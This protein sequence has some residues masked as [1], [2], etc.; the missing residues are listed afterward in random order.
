MFASQLWAA[1]WDQ[2]LPLQS[3]EEKAEAF[4]K[5]RA[6]I[7]SIADGAARYGFDPIA[8][9]NHQLTIEQLVQ[10]DA[11]YKSLRPSHHDLIELTLFEGNTSPT[12]DASKDSNWKAW[13]ERSA[14]LVNSWGFTS[15]AEVTAEI[16]KI[17]QSPLLGKTQ[18]IV[19]GLSNLV[20]G[21]MKKEFFSANISTKIEILK[22]HLPEEVISHGFAPAKLGWSDTE[23]SK[24]EIIRRLQAAS[25][26]DQKLTVLLVHDY[27][28]SPNLTEPK[29]YL[30]K[31]NLESSQMKSLDQWFS[32]N[33]VKMIPTQAAQAEASLILREIPP[34]VAI[35]R[36]FA[37]NDCSTK[38]SF[39]FV[40]SPNEFTFLIYDSKGGIK[41]YAQGTRVLANGEGTLYLHTIAGPRVSKTD[42][43][44]ILKT[45]SQEKQALGF[46]N[47]LIPPM[48]QV[49][50]M[51]N[52]LPVVE[53]IQEVHT[54]SNKPLQ[55]QDAELRNTLKNTF[56]ITVKYDDA[57]ENP[58]GHEIDESKLGTELRIVRKQALGL[59]K[60]STEIDKNSLI[61]VLLTMGQNLEKN[62]TMIRALAPHAE[63]PTETALTLIKLAKNEEKLTSAD[64]IERFE[65]NIKKAGF[66]FKE[67][68]FKKNL[69]WLAHGLLNSP[70]LL[71]NLPLS[72]SVVLSLVDQREFQ[73]VESFLLKNPSLVS[74]ENLTAS[75]LKSFYVDVHEA[76]FI[77]PKLLTAALHINPRAV[78]LNNNL[79]ELLGRA[80]QAVSAITDFLE[81]NPLWS[82]AVEKMAG[83]PFQEILQKRKAAI[84]SI[85]NAAKTARD[86]RA[87]LHALEQIKKVPGLTVQSRSMHLNNLRIQSAD[88]L[89]TIDSRDPLISTL[90]ALYNSKPN[91]ADP[92]VLQTVM[93]LLPVALK[94]A[95]W[96]LDGVVKIA[97]ELRTLPNAPADLDAVI[98][99]ALAQRSDAK[100][101]KLQNK[102]SKNLPGLNMNFTTTIR[103]EAIFH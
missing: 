15:N 101:K 1:T 40:N 92:V 60:V 2:H 54:A 18:G 13:Q 72:E 96:Q 45:F 63:I 95:D 70:D 102:I 84:S 9:F 74:S 44:K 17:L 23:I 10:S 28:Q 68:H 14:Q 103:C 31:W 53:A 11:E 24:S 7:P 80:P 93:K 35:F 8:L 88:Y 26:L 59:D 20:P 19:V 36:G 86:G 83:N 61:G 50:K 56:S 57:K 90:R 47:I 62:E 38:F 55:Y 42:A 6:M 34:S 25:D 33:V 81:L 79:L 46:K 12:G 94:N 21:A 49:K 51:N 48:D 73:L 16:Q 76:N 4:L 22:Q 87:Y 30:K 82:Q 66:N 65:R 32:A 52:F 67:G 64:F 91:L 71:S 100:T 75:V 29:D 27:S 58:I 43:L 78:L 77:E 99:S 89:L 97:A 41:G 98:A 85:L 69:S 37:G 5:I 39:P 3:T